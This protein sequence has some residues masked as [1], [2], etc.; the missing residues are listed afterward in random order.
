[1][2]D[3]TLVGDMQDQGTSLVFIQG[4]TCPAWCYKN[5]DQDPC[6]PSSIQTREKKHK[7]RFVMKQGVR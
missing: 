6:T 1:M 2:I 5:G 7:P 3:E 4:R